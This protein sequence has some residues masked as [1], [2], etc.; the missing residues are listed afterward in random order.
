MLTL[1]QMIV[2]FGMLVL[3]WMI[4]LIVY[5]SFKHH[6]EESLAR[7]HRIYTFRISLIVVPLMVAQLLVY[8]YRSV[9]VPTIETLS[10]AAIVV[11]MWLITFVVFVPLHAKLT[12]GV[13]VDEVCSRLVKFNWVRT[14][15]WSLLFLLSAINWL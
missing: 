9:K 2:D 14:I 1:W 5:P 4:Q 11:A 12:R 3:I 8:T 6:S 15:L 13:Q 10:G 7:W